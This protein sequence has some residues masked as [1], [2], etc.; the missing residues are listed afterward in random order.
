MGGE[1]GFKSAA[2][3]LEL[4]SEAGSLDDFVGFEGSPSPGPTSSGYRACSALSLEGCESS[5]SFDTLITRE[6]IP[7]FLCDESASV[8]LL[9][10]GLSRKG[11][12][13]K[14]SGGI[15]CIAPTRSGDG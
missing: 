6:S 15:G 3:A 1:F 9:C 4:P 10:C 12:G 2:E 13:A 14:P 7:G 8:A 5:T 11:L